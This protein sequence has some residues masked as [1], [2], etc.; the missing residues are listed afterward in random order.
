MDNS[1]SGGMTRLG[2]HAWICV[3]TDTLS[4]TSGD[5]HTLSEN[6]ASC[7]ALANGGQVRRRR[8]KPPGRGAKGRA[9][10]GN[11]VCNWPGSWQDP[12]LGPSATLPCAGL[13]ASGAAALG[14]ARGSDALARY[15]LVLPRTGTDAARGL[16]T[17]CHASLGKGWLRN[18]SRSP[19]SRTFCGRCC[20]LLGPDARWPPTASRAPGCAPTGPH[21]SLELEP[22]A[23]ETLP[24]RVCKG[25]TRH[26]A[27]AS[28][29]P[30]RVAISQ[31][32]MCAG[33][34]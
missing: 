24:A 31:E 17:A 10:K 6:D 27:A 1:S 23:C 14:N 28:S 7:N 26:C 20:K 21:S 29:D 8:G 30:R 16:L 18:P 2:R 4:S 3:R 13:T 34:V 25:L 22:T 19:S 9:E 5:C 12:Q 11:V 32:R 15:T 33:G